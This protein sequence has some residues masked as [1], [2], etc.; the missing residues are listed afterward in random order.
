MKKHFYLLLFFFAIT[1]VSQAQIKKGDILL[2]G[3]LSLYSQ[4]ATPDNNYPTPPNKQTNY[5]ISP[6]IG[7][8]IKDNLLVGFDLAFTGSKNT[9]GT[10]TGSYTSK[11]CT[12]GAGVF[13]RKYKP[14]GGGFAIFMQ[15]RFGGSYNTQKTQYEGDPYPY[16]N[17]K[18][19]SFDLSF[20]PGIAYAITKRVQLETGFANLVD[21]N[22][23]H[24]KDSQTTGVN[25]NVLANSKSN[26]FGIS[27]SLSNGYGFAVGI[28]VLLGS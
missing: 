25:N 5:N 8:A 26:S 15:T 10:G 19:Y 22:Y 3:T 4:K 28:K 12:Y 2:G 7:K 1:Y 24:S 6:S 13:L 27:T 14:L 21:V 16:N 20:Y 17:V 9:Q 23:S 18:G 11:S